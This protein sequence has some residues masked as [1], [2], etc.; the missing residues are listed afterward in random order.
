[1]HDLYESLKQHKLERKYGREAGFLESAQ[2][3]VNECLLSFGHILDCDKGFLPEELLA[4]NVV[5][6]LEGLLAENQA[7]LLTIL[8][9][10][11][12][13]YR[14]TSGHR[15]GLQ[16]IML[17]DEAKTVYS[18]QREFSKELGVSEIANFTSTIREF[19]EGLIVA[20]QMPTE[21]GDSIKA[22]VHTVISM[23]QSGAPNVSEMSRA[24][25]L[26]KEQLETSRGLQADKSSGIFE[27]IVKLNGR[28]MTPFVMRVF[29]FQIAKDASQA[30]I[31]CIMAPELEQLRGRIT[32]RTDYS[33][34]LEAKRKTQEERSAKPGKPETKKAEPFEDN[35]LIKILTNIREHPFIDQKTRIQTL[36]LPSSSS[37]NANIFRELVN[38]ELVEVHRIGLGRGKSSKVFYEITDKGKE[39]ASMERVRIPG[40]GSFRHKFWQHQIKRFYE[41]LGYLPEIE[42]RFGSKNVD[43][44]FLQDGKRVAVEVELSP[45]HLVKNIQKDFDAG[46]FR[47]IVAVPSKRS[48]NSYKKVLRTHGS[49]LLDDVD[50]KLLSDYL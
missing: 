48:I 6:E 14:I 33:Y 44:G 43:V 13:Q 10:Y 37:T 20:D 46:C 7:F 32:L 4:K 35:F 26:T 22:N 8:L 19:G 30:E 39:F 11:V 5:L 36:D 41:N 28:W 2:N 15:G 47:V 42:K 21:L 12:F 45:D 25:G 23:S 18:K 40:K 29:P 1:M 34:V 27:A 16:H 31:D 38:R 9:R 49:D 3:R 50:F 24:L 17:F